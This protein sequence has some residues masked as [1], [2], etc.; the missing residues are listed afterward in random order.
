MSVGHVKLRRRVFGVSRGGVVLPPGMLAP[1]SS[2]EPE[3]RV[4]ASKVLHIPL[5]LGATIKQTFAFAHPGQNPR[6][7]LTVLGLYVNGRV[8]EAK[9]LHEELETGPAKGQGKA[10]LEEELAKQRHVEIFLSLEWAAGFVNAP[11]RNDPVLFQTIEHGEETGDYDSYEEVGPGSW[12]SSRWVGKETALDHQ[13]LSMASFRKAGEAD[14]DEAR[15]ELGVIESWDEAATGGGKRTPGT[16]VTGQ[17][18][19]GR[20][21]S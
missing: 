12:G 11:A 6:I 10:G 16:V 21:V 2:G 18:A 8:K 15:L 9:R 1:I 7:S 4:S 17:A 13:V 19:I 14:V 3:R 20:A 5:T